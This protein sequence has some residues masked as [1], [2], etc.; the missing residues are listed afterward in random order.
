MTVESDDHVTALNAGL[1]GGTP[2]LDV[3]QA[4]AGR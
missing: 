3:L 4:G 2:R 1:V